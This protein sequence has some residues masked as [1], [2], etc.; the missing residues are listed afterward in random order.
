MKH[1]T[2]PALGESCY[3]AALPSGLQLRVVPKPGFA[4]KY[5]FLAVNVGSTDTTF[6]LDGKRHCVP[7]GIAHYL[8]HKMFDLPGQDAM[9]LFAQYGGNP[10]AFTSYGM[11]AYYFSCT[12]RF[13]DNLRLLLR[14]VTIPYFTQESVEKERGII[15]QEIRMYEDSA[16]SR[17]G[18]DLVAALFR[19]HPVRV[20]IAGTVE[21]IAEITP[22]LLTACHRAFYRAD[23]MMLCVVGDVD[24]ELV[25]TIA[26][27]GVPAAEGAPVQRDYGEAETML[28]VRT[29][30]E[31][32][33]S[34][35][36]PTF[37]LG[38]KCAPPKRGMDVMRRE[39]IGD[40]A[41]E[42]LAGESSPLYERLYAQGLI[43]SGFSVGYESVKDAC[44]LTAE[45]DS[46]DPEAVAAAIA[47]EAEH[48]AKDGFDRALFDRLK[49]SAMGRRMRG[50]DSFESI[51]YRICAYYFEGVEYFDFPAAYAA[52]TPEDVAQ[53]LNETL[54]PERACLATVLPK[55]E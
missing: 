13:E 22:E 31:R 33:M 14:M 45:G 46:S 7:D 52:V 41:G 27:E 35:S 29:R 5:A 3:T 8:E 18:E 54:R 42:I 10:N 20:P 51:C 28:P 32:R 53:F 47:A 21:S 34:V 40:L 24:A 49:K 48:L 2:Y 4:R 1:L 26:E 6:V 9:E 16:Q 11:T 19:S 30:S 55:E 50:L 38:Y 17:V 43:D 15:A 25:R 12:E 37:S 36:M 44:L 39:I 23:H